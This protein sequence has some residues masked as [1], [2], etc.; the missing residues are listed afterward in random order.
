MLLGCFKDLDYITALGV[1]GCLVY[2]YAMTKRGCRSQLK[3]MVN[4][5][6]CLGHVSNGFRKRDLIK[7]ASF[8]GLYLLGGALRT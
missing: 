6:K 2:T 1:A 5:G 8:R 7:A 4:G 3:L